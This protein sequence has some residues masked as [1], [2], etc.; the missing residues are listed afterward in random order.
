MFDCESQLA[1]EIYQSLYDGFEPRPE[2][3]AVIAPA[4]VMNPAFVVIEAV[5]APKFRG[6]G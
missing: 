1:L 4:D 5:G 6:R 3:E 2:V